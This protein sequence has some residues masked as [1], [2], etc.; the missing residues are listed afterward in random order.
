MPGAGTI[1]TAT[2]LGEAAQAIQGRAYS[3]LR[4]HAGVAPVTKQTGKAKHGKGSRR[5]PRVIMR[6]GCNGRL[7]NALYNWARVASQRDAA[8]GR[9]YAH[10]RERGHTHGRALRSVAD[11]LLRILFAMLREGTLYDSTR[12]DEPV[13]KAAA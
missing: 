4:A 1:V 12:F 8:S 10:L 6:H 9:Y 5:R 11:R 13:Q 2:M 3:A 7:R